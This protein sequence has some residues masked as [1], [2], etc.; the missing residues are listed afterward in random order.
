[1]SFS[2]KALV[3]I[4]LC[5]K[6]ICNSSKIEIWAGVLSNWLTKLYLGKEELVVTW[7]EFVTSPSKMTLEA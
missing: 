3:S 7:L 1:M 5:S 6:E 4:S 2:T